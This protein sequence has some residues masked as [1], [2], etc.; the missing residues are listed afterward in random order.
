LPLP[1][2]TVLPPEGLLPPVDE[3]S[4][5]LPV[6]PPVALDP[7]VAEEPPLPPAAFPPVPG[8]G[9]V[10]SVEQAESASKKNPE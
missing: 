7:P 9:G 2:V 8:G 6:D 5:P 3:I 10:A 1:P 4:P